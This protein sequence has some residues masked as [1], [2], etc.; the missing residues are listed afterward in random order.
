MLKRSRV[1]KQNLDRLLEFKLTAQ[2]A[3]YTARHRSWVF[4]RLRELYGRYLAQI[5][6]FNRNAELQGLIWH[7]AVAVELISAK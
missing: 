6:Y 5:G 2:A 7:P 4:H 1:R 3:A